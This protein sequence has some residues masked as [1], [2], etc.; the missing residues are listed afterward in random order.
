MI[1]L[2][3]IKFKEKTFLIPM[4][5]LPRFSFIV[6][7]SSILLIILLVKFKLFPLLSN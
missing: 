5:P 6:Q 2:H 4:D 7:D 3:L 1:G